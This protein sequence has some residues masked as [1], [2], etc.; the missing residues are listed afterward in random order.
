MKQSNSSYKRL[1]DLFILLSAH[2]ILFPLWI[3]LWVII[4]LIIWSQDGRPIFFLQDRIGKDGKIFKVYKFRTMVKSASEKG[5]VYTEDNDQRLMPFGALLRK[6]ALDELPQL[7]NILK[8]QMSFVGPRPFPVEEHKMLQQTL[9]DFSKRLKVLPGLTSLAEIYDPIDFP[10][11]TLKY[12]L[13][14]IEEMNPFLDIKI[15]VVS[16]FNTVLGKWDRRSGKER[17]FRM[18]NPLT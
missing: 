17:Y 5:P 14:Y 4:P 16:V 8:G 6:T 18:H 9:P 13:K 2:I 7:I 1:F 10:P 3:L 11:E 15:L 12:D